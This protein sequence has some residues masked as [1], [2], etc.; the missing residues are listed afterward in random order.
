M[1]TVTPPALEHLAGALRERPDEDVLRL[2]AG[3]T[4]L[5]L[6]PDRL[7][8]GDEVHR[9]ED[10]PVLVVDPTTSEQVGDRVLDL[11]QQDGREQLAL[12]RPGA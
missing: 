5:A 8:E 7:R 6:V 11:T 12:G 2:H 3:E 1:L 9:C 4:G 10:K